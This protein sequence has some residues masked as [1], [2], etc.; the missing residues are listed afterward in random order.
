MSAILVVSLV[1]LIKWPRIGFLAATFLLGLAPTSS[2]IPIVSE[3]GAER[4]M[5]LPLAGVAVLIAVGVQAVVARSGSNAVAK[6]RVTVM[7]AVS[8]AAVLAALATR[9]VF[10]NADYASPL[11]LWQTVVDRRPQGRARTSLAQELVRANRP[12]EAIAQLRAAVHDYPDARFGLGTELIVSGKTEEGLETLR[13]FISD[14]PGDLSRVPAR[15]LRGRTLASQERLDE[16]AEE[17][18]AILATAP[19][20][21]QARLSL[22]DLLYRPGTLSGGRQRTSDGPFSTADKL[23][24]SDQARRGSPRDGSNQRRDGSVPGGTPGRA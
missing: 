5:Y 23:D 11:T 4:R 22:G 18:R 10:R 1:A 8:F 6:S 19:N 2:I 13:A 9:T 16:A 14:K 3:V 17:Y 7:A 15:I 21:V 20:H 24:R 12:D